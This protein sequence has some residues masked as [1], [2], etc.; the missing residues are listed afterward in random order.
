MF[1]LS[2]LLPKGVRQPQTLI[3]VRGFLENDACGPHFDRDADPDRWGVSVCSTD[4][5][6]FDVGDVDDYF[7]IQSTSKVVT[8]A[9]ALAEVGEKETLSY[10]GAYQGGRRCTNRSRVAGESLACV[11]VT[12]YEFSDGMTFVFLTKTVTRALTCDPDRGSGPD[13]QADLTDD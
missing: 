7:S 2:K 6:Q 10:V 5:Q 13:T 12:P 3:A 4:G 11:I 1:S 8:F 9:T